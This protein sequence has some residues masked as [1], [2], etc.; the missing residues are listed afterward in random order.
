MHNHGIKLADLRTT[1]RA[2][3]PGSILSFLHL[4]YQLDSKG[5]KRL[6]VD[7]VSVT[8][9]A[10]EL[11]AIMGPSGAGKSTLLDLMAFRKM[12]LDGASASI[13]G[14]ALNASGMRQISTFVEHE[15]ALLGVLTVRETVSYALRLHLPKFSRREVAARVN[16]VLTAVGLQSCA[17]QPIGT[18]FSRGISAG[19]KRRV[20]AACA[21]VTFPR[22][23]LLDEVTSGLDSTSA[24]EVIA[25]IRTLSVEEGIIV[26]ATIHQPSLETLAQFTDI[27][28]LANG[29]TCFSGKVDALEGF[30][31]RWG[32]PVGRFI[33]PTD[34]AMN[35]LNNDFA[36][37][38][39]SCDG[40]QAMRE[41]YLSTNPS[42]PADVL[43]GSFVG[44][45]S[46]EGRA[47]A[48]GTLFWNTMV[49]SERTAIN[50]SRNLLAYGVRAGMYAGMGLILATIW[51][52][53]GDDDSK[54]DDRL[55]VHFFSAAFLAFMSIAGIPPFLEERSVYYR[56]RTNGLCST[57]PFVLSNMFI[58]MLFLFIC[59]LLY[60]LI[61]YWAVGLH[62]GGTAFFRF[63]GFLY[64]AILAGESQMLLIAALLPV[65]AG[66]L[67]IGSFING[68]WMAVGGYMIKARSLPRFWFYSFHYLD[69][70]RYTF[71]LL[72]NSDF[73]GLSFECGTIVNGTCICAYPSS[74][75]E[76]C[77]VSGADVLEYLEIGD[78]SYGAW[79]T[80]V[81]AITL[82]YRIALY[83]A[84]KVRSQ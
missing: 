19:Q 60:M 5:S 21:I 35:F 25:A 27:L 1:E 31:E 10:G 67:A 57:L 51:I 78:I 42:L 18:P 23:L 52:R 64:L 65:F 44:S 36:G 76:T 59:T 11:L 46:E 73:R 63:L 32:H 39:D 74:T 4:S 41:F 13:N 75:P 12:P 28:L 48:I 79:A 77:T 22:I 17:D 80:I 24:R 45:A 50:Y 72:A 33:T 16:R 47:G 83:F 58:N 82:I 37:R 26:I 30:L 68:V 40:A 14:K 84:L 66:A 9:K 29:R 7:G 38:H 53:L 2:A 6:L 56:E 71:E 8:V 20:T 70:Q 55:A 34:H 54:I 3:I 43:N 15:D 61:S 49:L 81:V 69:Y 62:P